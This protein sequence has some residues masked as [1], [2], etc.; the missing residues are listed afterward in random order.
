M[1]RFPPCC[2]TGGF[3]GRSVSEFVLSASIAPLTQLSI[4][5]ILLPSIT[6]ISANDL[7][8]LIHHIHE[9]SKG[10]SNLAMRFPNICIY[11]K[12]LRVIF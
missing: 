7:P 8:A 12:G 3:T 11:E 6:A 5:S 9:L 2:P 4:S 1:L 10:L